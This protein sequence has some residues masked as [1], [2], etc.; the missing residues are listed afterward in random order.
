MYLLISFESIQIIAAVIGSTGGICFAIYKIW[1]AY[2]QKNKDRE[3]L[4]KMGQNGKLEE[5]SIRAHSISDEEKII[6]RL[7]IKTSPQQAKSGTKLINSQK[8]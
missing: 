1:V 6:K 3:L 7:S 4:L 8:D 2:I 5:V